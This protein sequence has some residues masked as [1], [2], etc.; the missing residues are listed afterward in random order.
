[1]SLRQLSYTS[2]YQDIA[3]GSTAIQIAS[4]PLDNPQI[5]AV[6][7]VAVCSVVIKC[8]MLFTCNV[9]KSA[10]GFKPLDE[11]AAIR[12]FARRAKALRKEAKYSQFEFAVDKNLNLRRISAWETGADIKLSNIVKLC[13]ALEI[14][15]KDFFTEGFD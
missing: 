1:M 5:Y 6:Y 8:R 2:N 3:G 11:E 4:R 7:S 15:L 10:K 9:K 14:S 12:M 13:N